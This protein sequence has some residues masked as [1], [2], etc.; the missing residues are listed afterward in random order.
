LEGLSDMISMCQG[1]WETKALGRG[2]ASPVFSSLFAI[3]AFMLSNRGS[4][5]TQDRMTEWL[6]SAGFEDVKSIKTLVL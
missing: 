3:N 6:R 2:G 5:Y 1:A 4:L